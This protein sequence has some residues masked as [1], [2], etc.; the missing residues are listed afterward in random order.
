VER[1]RPLR[2]LHEAGDR[3]HARVPER[4]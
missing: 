3:A 4:S 1:Q 2:H